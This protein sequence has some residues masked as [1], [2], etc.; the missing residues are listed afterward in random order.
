MHIYISIYAYMHL[1]NKHVNAVSYAVPCACPVQEIS[2]RRGSTGVSIWVGPP[3]LSGSPPRHSGVGRGGGGPEPPRHPTHP[4][5]GQ[6]PGL[7]TAQTFK[8]FPNGR[9]N[10]IKC[11]QIS[12][13][14]KNLK[15]DLWNF[16]WGIRKCLTKGILSNFFKEWMPLD[17]MDT[18]I[19]TS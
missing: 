16:F 13:I 9:E 7:L 17:R 19:E 12:F 4:S 15:G 14:K 1:C 10:K 11:K 3:S 6:L 5:S 2:R 8:N 18:L